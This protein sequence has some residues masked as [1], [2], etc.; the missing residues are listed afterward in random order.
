MIGYNMSWPLDLVITK[1]A[2]N[3]YSTIASFFLRA[4]RAATAI[5]E[6]W[7]RLREI[8]RS[9]EQVSRRPGASVK[10]LEEARGRMKKLFLFRYSVTIDNGEGTLE[11]QTDRER[12]RP[13]GCS[14]LLSDKYVYILG[15]PSL[16][17]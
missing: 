5:S 11:R 4:K 7:V 8:D 13:D 16:C 15:S 6:S 3:L 14:L 2:L 12:E 10:K 17:L 1:E 9:L